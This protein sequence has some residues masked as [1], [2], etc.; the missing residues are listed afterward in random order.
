MEKE[1]VP[2]PE[3]FEL[4]QLGFDEPCFGKFLSSFQSNWKD[5][6]LILE[7]GMNETFEDN[8]NTYL[9]EKACSAPTFSQAIDFLYIYSNK[10]ID[11]QIKGSDSYEERNRKIR[12]GCKD[13]RH[14][15][16]SKSK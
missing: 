15:Q 11:I 16:N 5:Y 8:R 9:L 6:Q 4:K 1:F 10:Q 13:L 3:A 14:L 12:Q 7:L 2:Y